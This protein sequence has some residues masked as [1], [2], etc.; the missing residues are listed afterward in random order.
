M[1]FKLSQYRPDAFFERR[2]VELDRG[3]DGLRI[4]AKVLVDEDVTHPDGL[5]PGRF[6]SLSKLRRESRHSLSQARKMVHDPDL[7]QLVAFEGLTP[8]GAVLTDL[9]DRIRMSRGRS[10]LLLTEA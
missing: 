8:L 5:L 6:S 2:Q 4:D 1:L 9:I 7:D 10:A 3:P